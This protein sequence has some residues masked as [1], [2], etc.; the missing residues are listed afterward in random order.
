MQALWED[1]APAVL[2]SANR[3]QAVIDA[4]GKASNALAAADRVEWVP[5][6][7]EVMRPSPSKVP[8]IKRNLS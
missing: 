3:Y 1:P 5:A 2:I 6:E 8:E 7:P 4:G